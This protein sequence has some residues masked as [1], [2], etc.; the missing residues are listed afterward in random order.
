MA[1]LARLL[2]GVNVADVG[3]LLALVWLVVRLEWTRSENATAHAAITKNIDGVNQN[4]TK[5]ID[6]VNQ[7]LTKRIDDVNQSLTKRID[8][9]SQS[10]TKRIDDVNQSLTKRIDDVNQSLT[11][12]IEAVRRD[13]TRLEQDIDEVKQDVKM[14]L[15]GDVAWMQAALRDREHP[16]RPQESAR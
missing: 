15:T 12:D 16:D 4:L 6:D 13:F 11:K 3:V 8:D 14:L 7:S 2:E 9:V 5:N 1:V 10:L